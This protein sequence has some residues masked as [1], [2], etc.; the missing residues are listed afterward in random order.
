MGSHT[1]TSAAT[2]IILAAGE[3]TRMKSGHAKVSHQILGKP[4]IRWVVDA[5]LAGGCNRVIIVVGSH[6][7]EVRTLVKAAY[8][9]HP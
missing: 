9:R 8:A 7:D 1:M 2:A 4:M 6:A 5:A 3:G